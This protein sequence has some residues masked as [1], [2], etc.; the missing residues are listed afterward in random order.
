MYTQMVGWVSAK[1]CV[2]G[3]GGVAVLAQSIIAT[4]NGNFLCY[5]GHS[6]WLSITPLGQLPFEGIHLTTSP[7]HHHITRH[8]RGGRKAEGGGQ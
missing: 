2:C 7:H 4:G 1:S 5:A 6:G 8:T 3:G